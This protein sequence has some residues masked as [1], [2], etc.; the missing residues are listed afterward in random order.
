MQR[1]TLLILLAIVVVVL[2]SIYVLIGPP[3]EKKAIRIVTP[4]SIIASLPIWVA[5]ERKLFEQEQLQIEITNMTDSK[6]MVESLLAGNADVL[7][8]V[9]LA[10]LAAAGAPGNLPLMKAKIFS[11]SRMKKSPPFESLLVMAGSP[12]SSLKDIENKKIAVYP[13][14]SSELAVRY[15]LKTAGVDDTKVT[16]V[17]LPPPLHNE[18]LSQNDV[19][20]IH[21]YEPY[22]TASL[23]DG[24]TRELAGS[25]YAS[26]TDPCAIGTSAISRKFLYEHGDTAVRFYKVWDRAIQLIRE[27]PTDT[28]KILAKHLELPDSIAANATWVDATLTTETS[29][30]VLSKSV[31][32]LQTAGI[33]PPDFILEKDM[34]ASR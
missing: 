13:G 21:V 4:G 24:K 20:A 30:D 32:V 34:V 1:R 8:A 29:F 19:Q 31:G 33:I 10:D 12:L 5:Q 14:I 18:R 23:A 2:A 28:R 25:I 26:L 15:Y 3:P 17:K 7:P 22:R 6:L 11:Y 9:S 16:F 27:N